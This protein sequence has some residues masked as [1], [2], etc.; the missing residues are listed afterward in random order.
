MQSVASTRQ[1]AESLAKNTGGQAFFNS[2]GIADILIRV[3]NQ[4][5]HYYTLSYTPTKPQ[6]DNGYRHTRIESTNAKYNLS[7]RRGYYAT[8]GIRAGTADTKDPLLPLVGFGLPDMAQIIYVLSVNPSSAKAAVSSGK[9]G[10]H[11]KGPTTHYAL[12][13]GVWPEAVKLDPQPDGVRRAQLE[14]AVVAYDDA[15]KVLNMTGE[16]GSLKLT[17]QAL[18]EAQK[19]GIHFHEELDLPSNA[20]VHLR[21]GI[22]DLNSGN[23]G[24]LGVKVRTQASGSK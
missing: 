22:Y 15:G 24:T 1:T 7:Y 11:L 3:T 8:D 4:G 20:D 9:S 14:V 23:A 21:T 2:N 18:Q 6:A 5:M 19:S 10:T 17:P 16:R 12:D 13:F